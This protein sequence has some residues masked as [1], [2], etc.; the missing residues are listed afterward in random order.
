M[1]SYK[2]LMMIFGIFLMSCEGLVDDINEN[3][4]QLLP[5]ELEPQLLLKGTILANTV[6]QG[7]HVN[8]I[9]AMWSG[10]LI[11]FTSLYSNIYGYNISTAESVA[12]WSRFYIGMVPNLRFIRESA[13][14]QLRMVAICKIL[15]AHAIGTAASLFGDVPYREIADVNIDDPAFDGQI[16]VLND[17]VTL[18]QSAIDDL[19]SDPPPTFDS[20]VDLYFG[21]DIVAWR[22]TAYTLMAR[23]QLQLKNYPAAYAAAQNGIS[24]DVNTMRY[25]PIESGNAEGDK[26][27][28][29]QILQGPRQG[30][31][32][33][34]NSYMMQILDPVSGIYRGNAKTV[35]DARFAYFFVD[36]DNNVQNGIAERL[37]PNK[38]ITYAENQLILAEAGARSQS[39]AVG[40]GHLNDL[41]AWLA[42]GGQLLNGKSAINPAFVGLPIQ[43]DAYDAADFAPGGMENIDGIDDTRALLREIM[44]ERFVSGFTLFMAFNDLRRLNGTSEDDI[45][46]PIPFNTG[47]ATQHP[48]RLPYSNDEL[49]TNA[50]S[51]TEDP[52]IYFVNEVNR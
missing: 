4:N 47:T 34:G 5:S 43:Y 49:L 1:K 14:T 42:T 36:A 16:Q 13:P 29:W 39:F 33:T 3:P 25:R 12:T 28:M 41:R 40:L 32:G 31:I 18:L 37:E 8:R 11:G 2:I 45:A 15:E 26:N 17:M 20:S 24:T 44:E 9:S 50:N 38:L 21:G 19:A 35:E 22:E 51:P 10:Q 7:G 6:A 48:E 52:G 27:L 23:Y 46:V 30:D